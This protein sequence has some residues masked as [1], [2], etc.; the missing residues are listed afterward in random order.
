ALKVPSSSQY[1]R[2][3][4]SIVGGLGVEGV[5]PDLTHPCWELA[6]GYTVTFLASTSSLGLQGRLW[7]GTTLLILGP[8]IAYCS[9]IG[10]TRSVLLGCRRS[11][12]AL[13]DDGRIVA[14][15][16]LA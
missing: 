9:C 5:E 15:S 7:R 6:R 1:L 11:S 16:S 13:P 10:L 14:Q 8:K 12:E 3:D 2:I 4:S